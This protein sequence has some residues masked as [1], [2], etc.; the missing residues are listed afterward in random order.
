MRV[1]DCVR[2]GDPFVST[3]LASQFEGLEWPVHYLDFE[4]V[5]TALPLY[6]DLAPYTQIPTQYSLHRRRQPGGPLEHAEYLADPERDCQEEL[7]ERLLGDCGE[8]GS[9]V[10]Y[11]SFE[12]TR[13]NALAARVPRL[14]K[15]LLMLTERLFDLLLVVQEGYYH[16][17]FGGSFSIKVV[18]PVLVPELRYDGLAVGDGDAAV[19]RFAK[20]AMGM[21][22]PA[23]RDQVRRDLLAYCEMD[24]LAMARLHQRLLAV[25]MRPCAGG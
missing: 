12:K 2:C 8:K 4:T 15:R 22:A 23:D 20:M 24:T 14:S 9:V 21:Y 3:A 19:A 18:L 17:D 11:S 13:I 25:A 10:V 6:D 7:A 5:M 16:P 1:V